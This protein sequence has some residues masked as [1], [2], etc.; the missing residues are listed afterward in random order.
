[1]RLPSWSWPFAKWHE[2]LPFLIDVCTKMVTKFQCPKMVQRQRVTGRT[3]GGGGVPSPLSFG[4]FWGR[5]RSMAGQSTGAPGARM[6]G[7][8]RRKGHPA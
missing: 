3:S 8:E 6:R 2:L 4:A 5:F 1:M 7:A